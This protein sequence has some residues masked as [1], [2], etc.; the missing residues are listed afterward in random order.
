MN[1]PRF[2]P[3]QREKAVVATSSKLKGQFAALT[4]EGR[5][6]LWA[7]LLERLEAGGKF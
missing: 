3:T 7:R 4:H 2:N 5:E 1:F 6:R